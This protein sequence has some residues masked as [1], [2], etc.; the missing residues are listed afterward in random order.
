[1][2]QINQLL[3]SKCSLWVQA[4]VPLILPVKFSKK[5]NNFANELFATE[6]PQ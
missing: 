2:F 5:K 6:T 1:M 4:F 3:E